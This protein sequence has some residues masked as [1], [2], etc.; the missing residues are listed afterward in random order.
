MIDF[1]E[2]NDFCWW[3]KKRASSAEHIYKKTDLG[4]E[5]GWKK[6]F[7]ENQPV[8]YRNED[9][10]IP[11][12]TPKSKVVKFSKNLCEECNTRKSQPFDSAYDI[13]TCYFKNYEKEIFENKLINFEEIYGQFWQEKFLDLKR[14]YVKNFCCQLNELGIEI[15]SSLTDFMNGSY[16]HL[17]LA[18]RMCLRED[19]YQFLNLPNNDTGFL[20]R[21]G[22]TGQKS[23]TLEKFYFLEGHIC[24]RSFTVTY[25]YS[26]EETF[27]VPDPNPSLFLH[28]LNA[29]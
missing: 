5:F 29:K 3:C 7:S 24:Y 15:L 6:S 23:K 16:N 22:I 2:K 26:N 11:I 25:F 13:F 8:I 17:N 19:I 27:E 18:I 10:I 1:D 20:H 4:R 28:V 14:Y 12:E 9:E 21:S